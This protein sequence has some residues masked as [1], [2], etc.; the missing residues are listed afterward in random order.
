[1]TGSYHVL[2]A[3][4]SDKCEVV[5]IIHVAVAHEHQVFFTYNLLYAGRHLVTKQTFLL[6]FVYELCQ[7]LQTVLP[8]SHAVPH[9]QQC[10]LNTAATYTAQNKT[11]KHQQ[12]S[13]LC[14]TVCEK[15]PG[16]ELAGDQITSE[17]C[18]Q[19]A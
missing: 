18:T 1:M 2:A 15:T 6:S 17:A 16:G 13:E 19:L 14:C 5:G 10:G 7:L 12:H 11:T 8:L 4:L 9:K 3:K